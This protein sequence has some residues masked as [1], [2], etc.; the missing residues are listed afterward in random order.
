MAK[1]NCMRIC[2]NVDLRDNDVESLA[3][4]SVFHIIAVSEDNPVDC[5]LCV[6]SL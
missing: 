1:V 2:S 6:K 3:A 4:K 5:V